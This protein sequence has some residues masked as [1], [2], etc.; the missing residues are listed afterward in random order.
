MNNSIEISQYLKQLWANPEARQKRHLDLRTARTISLTDNY[1][2]TASWAAANIATQL[3]ESTNFKANGCLL[4][5]GCGSGLYLNLLD[6]SYKFAVGMDKSPAALAQFPG[7][8][9]KAQPLRGDILNLPFAPETF[10]AAMANRMLNLT[11]AIQRALNEIR[12]VLV[13][14][15]LLFIVTA[16][17]EEGA[18][19]RKAHEAALIESGFPERFYTR[20]SPPDQRLGRENGERWL[21]EAGFEVRQILDYER[22]IA[23]L[24]L[25]EALE[26]YATGLLFQRSLGFDEPGIEPER[27]TKLYQA[28][29]AR[30]AALLELEGKLEIR[31][32]ATLFTAYK[33][34]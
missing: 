14:Q 25:A 19:L 32:G 13:T 8:S 9:E 15:G 26:L 20:S 21:R 29:E 6:G 27:W 31:D 22:V 10:G 11:G 24:S 2:D 17:R 4:D 30:L 12:R 1:P 5:V 16:E 34:L 18:T 28:M 33:S 3:Q 23:P 7:N